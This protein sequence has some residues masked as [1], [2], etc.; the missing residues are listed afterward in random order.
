MFC[1]RL[2]HQWELG[3]MDLQRQA[4]GIWERFSKIKLSCEKCNP[5]KRRFRT[6]MLEIIDLSLMYCEKVIVRFI[7][8]MF[9]QQFK[10]FDAGR[11]QVSYELAQLPLVS[12]EL[13]HS[14][15]GTFFD[16]AS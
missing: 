10:L 7:T 5:K 3:N 9:K 13:A 6:F 15:T 1:S 4:L 2:A 11:P 12:D 8:C 14:K 16:P